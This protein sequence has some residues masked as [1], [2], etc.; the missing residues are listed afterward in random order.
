MCSYN[1]LNGVPAC[2]NS[3]LLQ[4]LARDAWGLEGFVVS[5]C[6]AVAVIQNPHFC[7]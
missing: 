5:D 6:D 2:G 1:A 4:D 7:E 3:F